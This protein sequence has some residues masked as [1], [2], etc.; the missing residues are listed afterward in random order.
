ME[1]LNR[2][3][4]DKLTNKEKFLALVSENENTTF[5]DI[6]KAIKN[7]AVLKESKAIAIEVLMRMEMDGLK[8][9]HLAEKLGLTLKQINSIVQG[10]EVLSTEIKAKVESF[11]GDI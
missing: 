11:L 3:E 8:K 6:E 9:K 5:A 2:M 10:R 7:V 4:K 1:S